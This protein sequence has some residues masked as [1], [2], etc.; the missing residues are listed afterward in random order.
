MAKNLET[1]NPEDERFWMS[2][3]KRIATRNLWISIPCLL[4]GFAVWLYWGIITVQ[5]IN[6]KFPFT[7]AELFTLAA[8]AGLSGA[9][10][11]ISV[12][13]LHSHRG[14][15]QH[16]RVHDGPAD[17]SGGGDRIP[18]A[19]SRHAA[20]AV[21]GHGAAFGFRRREFRLV[22]VEHILFLSEASA[23]LFARHERRPGQFR[24]YHDADSCATGYDGR[25]FRRLGAGSRVHFGNADREDSGR[26]R[27]VYP[28]C[29]LRVGRHTRTAGDRRLARNEQHNRRARHARAGFGAC[30]VR[31]D[32]GHADDRSHRGGRRAL[33]A[34]AGRCGRFRP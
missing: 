11:R 19:E 29:R 6:L 34:A 17:Y 15:A 32:T 2:D 24:R 8:I 23:G 16:D 13:V 9:T 22:D 30:G 31:Q 7:Q 12:V 1:W 20:L 3:G 21:P 18:F 5:M 33:A 10:L 25:T 27:D 28:Q 26:N 14:R 4:A